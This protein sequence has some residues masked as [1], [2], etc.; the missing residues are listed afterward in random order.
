MASPPTC[1]NAAGSS[2]LSPWSEQPAATPSAAVD[3]TG[4]DGYPFAPTLGASTRSPAAGAFTP[5]ALA[6]GR[7]DGHQ[8]LAGVDVNL[9]PGLLGMLARVDQC[10]DA[11]AATGACPAGSRIGT[12]SVKAGPG[13]Q[14]FGLSGPAYL[15]GPY[16]G[17][18]F[19]MVVVIRAIAGPFDLGTVVVRQRIQVDPDDAHISV[20]SDPLPQI[21]EGVPLRLRS[22]TVD[23]DREGFM[24]NPTSCGTK[25]VSGV[26]GSALGAG[27]NVAA[28][29]PVDACDALAFAPKLGL[30][31][32]GAKQLDEGEHPGVRATATQG[33]NEAGIQSTKV[34]LPL[35]LALDPDNA[36]QL[37]SVEDGQRATCPK[38]SVI[39]GAS[40]TS[41]ILHK[42]LSG[43]VYFVQGVRTD[44]TTGRQIRTL[45]T[46]LAT[47]RGE[48]A[49]NV[50]AATSVERGRLVTTFPTLPDAPVSRFAL[51]IE[52]GRHGILVANRDVCATKRRLIANGYFGAHN[53]K[54]KGIKA[55]IATPC[56]RASSKLKLGTVARSG[57]R[58]LVS[59]SLAKAAA[60]RLKVSARCAG[61][62]VSK[63]AR[64][65]RGRW[66]TA[67]TL[68]ARCASGKMV[69]VTARYAGGNGFASA[70][71]ARRTRG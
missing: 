12:A 60:G 61:K 70:K 22:V 49:I 47:L 38:E 8:P 48:V 53:G 25:Q 42:P 45:P 40:A 58:L 36:E 10:A 2:N 26:L 52:G 27:A 55:A 71:R 16:K 24:R 65:R 69:T 13:A 33:E 30:R 34:S 4:C 67:L 19:G 23:V 18:P 15:T 62:T 35:A 29:F 50:R 9:P 20:V 39:G 17:A 3:V 51:Q 31:L 6:L 28:S 32:I 63:Q 11:Q 37:C 64:P 54:A 68:P 66:R 46:L 43:P 41:P 56:T 1:G 57:K 5:F 21:L 44:P 59:G 14:P 7:D